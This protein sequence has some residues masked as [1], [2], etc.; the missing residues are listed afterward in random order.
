[1]KSKDFQLLVTGNKFTGR[2]FRAIEPVLMEIVQ[3]AR[4]EIYVAAYVVTPLATRLLDMLEK[5]LEKGIRVT[6]V[7]D[8]LE[9]Q[10]S[11][12]N[13]KL[14]NM[15]DKFKNMRLV[16]FCDPEGGHL[17]AKAIIVDRRVAVIGSANLTWGGLVANHELAFLVYG[18]EAWNIASLLDAIT[19]EY[20]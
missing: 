14:R 10:P 9:N 18:D 15:S 16:S 19:P 1:M 4:E 3:S 17:H 6:A 12:I 20:P 8:D 7:I 11:E 2:G 5:A 13:K